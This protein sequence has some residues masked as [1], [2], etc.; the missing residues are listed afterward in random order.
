[1]GSGSGRGAART[2]GR[3]QPRSWILA[4]GR[5]D[6]GHDLQRQRPAPA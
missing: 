3:V 5:P 6:D 4:A 2:A 1:M